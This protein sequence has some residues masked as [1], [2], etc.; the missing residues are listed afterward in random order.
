MGPHQP[1]QSITS[2][3]R[4]HGTPNAVFMSNNLFLGSAGRVD[5]WMYDTPDWSEE[6]RFLGVII[7]DTWDHCPPDQRKFFD[8][9]RFDIDEGGNIV[10][11]DDDVAP[12]LPEM[13]E[14]YNLIASYTERIT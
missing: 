10:I 1:K 12:S 5:L 7:G 4:A 9:S 14:I 11:E 2:V 13:V 3:C 6:R 8:W